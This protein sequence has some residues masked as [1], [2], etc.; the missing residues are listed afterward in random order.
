MNFKARQNVYFIFFIFY[1]KTIAS[2]EH[3][4]I[5]QNKYSR[6]FK[7]FQYLTANS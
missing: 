1:N 6:Y 7:K 4:Y 3:I 2:E 5:K